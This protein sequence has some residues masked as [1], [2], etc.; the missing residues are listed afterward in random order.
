MKPRHLIPALLCA[1]LI[2]YP[3]SVGPVMMSFERDNP[4]VSGL[5]RIRHFYFP[6]IWASE[7]CQPIGDSLEWY[8]RLWASGKRKQLE[9]R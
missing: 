6:L 1:L 3:L 9:E 7:H 5:L 8:V 2:A 4:S